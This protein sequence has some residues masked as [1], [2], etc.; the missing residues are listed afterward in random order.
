MA[1]PQNDY[2]IG[3]IP[4]R[5]LRVNYTVNRRREYG[6]L[7]SILNGKKQFRHCGDIIY[8]YI[9]LKSIIDIPQIFCMCFEGSAL[10]SL[11]SPFG[12]F[13]NFR[14]KPSCF[15]IVFPVL[16]TTHPPS[17]SN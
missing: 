10:F 6:S 3:I 1:S 2:F 9:Y 11:F 17:L 12:L 13:F 4:K 16:I 5:F 7:T 8:I 15:L 14:D